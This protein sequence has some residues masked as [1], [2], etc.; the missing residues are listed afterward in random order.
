MGLAGSTIGRMAEAPLP[1]PKKCSSTLAAYKR[2][3][4]LIDVVR[5]WCSHAALHLGKRDRALCVTR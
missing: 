4:A 3:Q 2:I 1:C 5:W